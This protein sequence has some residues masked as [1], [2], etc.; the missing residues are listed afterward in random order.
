MGERVAILGY[1]GW[2]MFWNNLE[3][4]RAFQQGSDETGFS[5]RCVCVSRCVWH[6]WKWFLSV[7]SREMLGG[8]A[9]SP[10]MCQGMG[11]LKNLKKEK[12]KI[13]LVIWISCCY[14]ATLFGH[15]A[16][17][18]HQTRCSC[19]H[20]RSTYS[21]WALLE[22]PYFKTHGIRPLEWPGFKCMLQRYT[23]GEI[24]SHHIWY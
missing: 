9:F 11:W 5:A 23:C 7:H 4:V 17:L 20:S 15:W 1:W 19:R 18:R 6:S 16:M 8:V 21:L 14:S 10:L 12:A 2:R 24:K 22:K 13:F 3:A